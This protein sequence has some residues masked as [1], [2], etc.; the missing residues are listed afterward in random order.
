MS[1]PGFASDG[2]D[3]DAA[4]SD[5]D[6]LELGGGVSQ[7][8]VATN[9]GDA[10]AAANTNGTSSRAAPKAVPDPM[11]EV[12]AFKAR[13]NEHFTKR[14]YELAVE[15]YTQAIEA[16][17]GGPSGVELLRLEKAWKDEQDKAWRE[18]LAQIDQERRE[19]TKKEREATKGSATSASAAKK[20]RGYPDRPKETF[21]PPRHP[22]GSKLAVYHG[23]RAAAYVQLQH[24]D[25]AVEDCDVA[26]LLDATYLKALVRRATAYEHL[27]KTDLALAD[28]Q[29]ALKR[30]PANFELR[31]RRDRLQ[32][33]ENERLERLKAE[34]MDKLKDLGNSILGN[35]G[36]SLDNFK[37][38]QDP[39]TGS[40]SI[41]FQQNS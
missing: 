8:S 19:E 33:L 1:D 11:E 12:E 5:S 36:L 18:K 32:K 40:Y 30:D 28:V 37:A 15:L 7:L 23:N 35:F 38:T 24:Y 10:A 16:T 17:P 22:H 26:L 20:D 21:E 3:L 9:A 2:F 25:R 4:V 34:T 31:K 39:N 27:D 14:E 41:N 29:A 13:G 6:V